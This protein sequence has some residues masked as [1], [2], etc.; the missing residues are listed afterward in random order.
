MKLNPFAEQSATIYSFSSV[1]RTRLGIPWN[2]Q[3]MTKGVI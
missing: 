2:E 3:Q 1:E